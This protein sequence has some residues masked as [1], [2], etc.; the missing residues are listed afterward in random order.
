V[1]VC[2]ERRRGRN[3][4]RVAVP[5][6]VA[7]TMLW[8]ASGV[9]SRRLSR[10]IVE[11]ARVAEDIGSGRLSS[12]ARFR[13]HPPGEIRMLAEVINDMAARIERTLADQR[14]L[15]AAVSH[16]IRTPLARMRLLVEM[17][18]DKFG[19]EAAFDKLDT[20]VQ[21]IDSLVGDLLASSRVDF[22]AL[23]PVRLEAERVAREALDRAHVDGAPRD[24][25]RLV[26]DTPG[27]AFMGDPTLV[28]RALAN[29]VANAKMHAGGVTLLRVRA[30]GGM[31]IF[32]VED[33]GAGFAAGEEVR[34]FEP[35]YRRGRQGASEGPSVGLGLTLVRRIAEAHGG[36]AYARNRTPRGAVVAVEFAAAV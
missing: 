7:L 25:A 23:V 1:H 19:D 11:L 26:V 20:E 29:L 15:L 35:F 9:I 32:E 17:A 14:A 16:E 36:T 30:K 12:R 13:G 2:F 6:V 18:R 8:A 10:P 4:V 27:L 24:S 34:I 33:E 3:A 5:I 21:D 31:V 22:A 28:A